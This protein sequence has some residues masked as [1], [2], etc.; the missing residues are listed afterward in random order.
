[1]IIENNVIDFAIDAGYTETAGDSSYSSCSCHEG[2]ST[3]SQAVSLT[4][5]EKLV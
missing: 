2:P 1:M 5:L 4:L 3:V